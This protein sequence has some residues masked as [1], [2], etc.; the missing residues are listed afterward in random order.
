MFRAALF[1][2]LIARSSA[3]ED[4]LALTSPM[5]WRD[6]NLYQCNVNQQIMMGTMDLI[7]DA[8]RGVS[9]A[10]LGYKD[11]GLGA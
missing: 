2:A 9:L 6:W 11:V 8:G 1:A 7:A 5:G 10:A 4:G 3:A